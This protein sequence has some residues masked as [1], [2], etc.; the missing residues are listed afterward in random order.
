MTAREKITSARHRTRRF[1]ALDHDFAVETSDPALGQYLDTVFGSLAAPGSAAAR[2]AIVEHEAAV[3]LAFEDEVLTTT[4][5]PTHAVALLLWHVNQQAVG[6]STGLVRLHAAGAARGGRAVVLP[7]PMEYGK[8]TL[9]AGLVK[10]GLDY[11]SDEVV[12]LDP[13]T[14]SIRPYPKA[15][16]VDPG[17]WAVL[18]EFRPIVEPAAARFV[19]GQ[20]Q[21]PPGAIRPQAV[22]SGAK[23]AI[24][25]APRYRPGEP[26]RLVPVGR[27]E[28]VVELV[29]STFAFD[30]EPARNL[31]TLGRLASEARCYRLSVADLDEA[32]DLVLRALDD[33]RR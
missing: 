23:P 18:S 27:A 16:S 30:R 7:A 32:C 25:V 21:V 13:A 12:A 14:L 5:D 19:P 10:A 24:V 33:V 9:V 17:S 8:T 2:Y 26:T 15:L 4:P 3:T 22:A 31:P 6:T 11:L 1:R 29:A 28:M 20:W